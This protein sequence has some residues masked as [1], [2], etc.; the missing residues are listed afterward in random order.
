MNILTLR[1]YAGINVANSNLG[2][3]VSAEPEPVGGWLGGKGA[4][5]LLRPGY[6]TLDHNRSPFEPDGAGGTFVSS[7]KSCAE[8]TGRTGLTTVVT[9]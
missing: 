1:A 4:A 2:A 3:T 9:L 6:R 5:N 8:Y 7:D